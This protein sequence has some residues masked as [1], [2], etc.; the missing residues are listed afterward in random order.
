M[1]R[2]R[3]H[4]VE[5]LMVTGRNKLQS[6]VGLPY[7]SHMS[8]FRR[9]AFTSHRWLIVG[10]GGGDY[11]INA[12]LTQAFLKHQLAGDPI[13]IV[14]VDKKDLTQTGAS[15]EKLGGYD[16]LFIRVN[17]PYDCGP[18]V[19]VVNTNGLVGWNYLAGIETLS[20]RMTELLSYL[21]H[22]PNSAP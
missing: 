21:N 8:M 14:F 18:W 11:H 3:E 13:S 19:P 12:V 6:L 16:D 15:I 10:Y 1:S 17:P 4:D 9:Q 7:S 2:I 22:H 5:L 20:T